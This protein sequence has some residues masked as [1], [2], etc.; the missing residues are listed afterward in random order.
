MDLA[1]RSASV[2]FTSAK[3]VAVVV[4]TVV[5]LVYDVMVLVIVV[6]ITVVEYSVLCLVRQRMKIHAEGDH[7]RYWCGV[8]YCCVDVSDTKEESAELVGICGD[9]HIGFKWA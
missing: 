3:S 7:V 9:W 1:A 6:S 4:V 2:R 5:V 8:S